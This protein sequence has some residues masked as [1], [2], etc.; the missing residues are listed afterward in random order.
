M[1]K[2]LYVM[3]AATCV[4]LP[5]RPGN[6]QAPTLDSQQS[7]FLTLINNYRAQN[8][9]GPLQVSVTLQECSQWMSND[10]ATKNYFSHT[11]SLGRDPFT[12]MAA[13]GY[14]YYPEGEN[15]AAG[16]S[17]AQVVFTAWQ[18]ACDPDSNGNCTYAHR[19][20][21]LNSSYMA[22][23]IGRAYSAT[24]TYGWYWTTDFGAYVDLALNPT[25]T[26]T[27]PTISS[28]TVNPSTIAPGQPVTLSWNVSGAT[29]IGIDNGV[30]TV[31]N[32]TSTTV[33]PTITT[34]YTLTATNSTGST[35]ASV[36]VTVST[37]T[38]IRVNAGGPAYI[39]SA[40]IAWS[41]DI[42]YA[43]G[44]LYSAAQAIS[45]TV[46]PAL[47]QTCRYGSS[48]S[49]QYSVPNGTYAVTLKFA[50][51]FFNAAG[52]RQFNV[53]INGNRVLT[54]F[55]IIA[56][57]GGSFVALD[58]S[59]PVSVTGG[60]IAIQFGSGNANLPVINGIEI[61]SGSPPASILVNSGGGNYTD[62]AG[63]SWNADQ[64]Y[65]GGL[66]WSTTNPIANT[67]N[68]LIYQTCRYGPFTYSFA[69]PNGTYAVILKFAEIYHLAA[70]QRLFN[71]AINGVTVLSGFDIFAQAGGPSL[72]L[73]EA[74][75]VTVTGG[76]IQI[77][78]TLGMADLPM[79]NG[80][81]IIPQ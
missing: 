2:T 25:P 69:V 65:S 61:L 37:F 3:L 44:A 13:F 14:S 55:D 50:E 64:N 24:S 63:N 59:F 48:F 31:T 32:L 70:G 27:A 11:D 1:M 49:Y 53:A 5:V 75:P 78:F 38:P 36:T 22:I 72:A 67:P 45:D 15:L 73:D 23:G 18:T 62:T 71:V 33:T 46:S 9:V 26:A 66:P 79:V 21:M 8:G 80:I 12:R 34:T 29:L 51:P 43:G 47:Y 68:A 57:A 6:A 17:D 42:G 60:Q 76:Q 30:G 10:M 58:K 40:G 20:N 41:A 54:N 77:Q 74:F 19:Q 16:Y 7:A 81:E 52:Q 4:F 28:F 35:T 56:E 39:D